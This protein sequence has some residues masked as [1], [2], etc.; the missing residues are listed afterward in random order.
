MAAYACAFRTGLSSLII[1]VR[2]TDITC[3]YCLLD[4]QLSCELLSGSF[5]CLYPLLQL[6]FGSNGSWLLK[7]GVI[8]KG[9]L[10]LWT[11][12]MEPLSVFCNA[13]THICA[14]RIGI[15]VCLL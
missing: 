7:C 9:L 8:P 5:A 15:Q 12:W 1:L 2:N 6:M 13:I 10:L 3:V 11:T 4:A 14:L